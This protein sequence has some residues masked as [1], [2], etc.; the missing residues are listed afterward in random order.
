LWRALSPYLLVTVAV[1]L[2]WL[3]SV[4]NYVPVA[5]D[6]SLST[7][8]QKGLGAWI[9]GL[10]V[11]R[12][13]GLVVPLWAV[14]L[15]PL[16]LGL[17]ALL[18][19]VAAVC[20]FYKVCRTLLGNSVL[21]LILA[22]AMGIFPWGYQ[23]LL[24]AS[25]LSPVL[26]NSLFWLNILVLLKYAG[27]AQAQRQA[28]IICFG[29]TLLSLLTNDYLLFATLVSGV[30]IWLPADGWS[31]A[32]ARR[33]MLSRYS[34][35]APFLAGGAYLLMF[36]LL[37]AQAVSD[38]KRPFLNL[39]SILSV[40]YH[41]YSNAYVFQPWLNPVTRSFLFF[42]WGTTQIVS[43]LLLT[44]M[45]GALLLYVVRRGGFDPG[46]ARP[47]A[48]WLPYLMLLLLGA[49]LVYALTGGYS[50]DTRK[51]YSLIPLLL[52]LAGWLWRR[53]V[54]S[55][56]KAS[57]WARLALIV[58]ITAGV[59]TTWM[60]IGIWRYEVTRQALLVDY[61]AA[62]Q[63]SGEIRLKSDPDLYA[64]WPQLNQT[65]GFR[66]D[67]DWV[68]NTA[69]AYRGANPVKTNG[70]QGSPLLSFDAAQFRWT[71]VPGGEGR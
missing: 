58:L 66:L 38:Y 32:G 68:L 61:L 15:H 5:D 60:V 47:G 2:A 55:G 21:A 17:L 57:L 35:W 29:L 18:A 67:D 24:W 52:L 41:Q 12:I 69:L 28:F 34:G 53:F 20:C 26:A 64:A 36:R 30:I 51:K 16:A 42:S 45:L 44:A 3:P 7:M 23:A 62:H 48:N 4:Y 65:M 40:Y 46:A 27:S 49:S 25:G 10:G 11:W 43:A 70:A 37:S 54:R 56:P 19:H 22:L 9:D 6:F 31:F 8:L 63:L 1:L 71:I 59:S 33:R 14:S 13:L 39:R 50:L